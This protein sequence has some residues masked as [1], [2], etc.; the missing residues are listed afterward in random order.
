MSANKVKS[1]R[2]LIR[3]TPEIKSLIEKAAGLNE[4][5]VADWVRMAAIERSRAALQ[6]EGL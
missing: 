3:V 1:E 4:R 5:S 2:I 6:N